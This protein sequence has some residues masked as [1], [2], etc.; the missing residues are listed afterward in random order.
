MHRV[1]IFP[2]LRS[3]GH[4][5]HSLSHKN[6]CFLPLTG[7]IVGGSVCMLCSGRP[8]G[9]SRPPGLAEPRAALPSAPHAELACRA[10]V[11]IGLLVAFS[12]VSL[13][14][15]RK[16]FSWRESWGSAVSFAEGCE[17]D[18]TY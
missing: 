18:Q 13:G 14:L 12:G 17:H 8:R 15:T 3:R 5:S 2:S 4:A 10:G 1:N 16:H 6:G 7:R 9:G 11:I